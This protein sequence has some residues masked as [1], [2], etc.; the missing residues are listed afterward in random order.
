MCSASV[1]GIRVV[2]HGVAHHAR[3]SR[4]RLDPQR[5]TR[6]SC[7]KLVDDR[8][9]VIERAPTV[10]AERGDT[11]RGDRRDHIGRTQAHHRVCS[12]VE[13][14]RHDERQGAD[15]LH[16]LD[17][18]ERLLECEERLEHEQVDTAV[19]ECARLLGICLDADLARQQAVRLRQLAGRA[20][21]AGNE[22]AVAR[23]RSRKLRCADVQLAAAPGE[24]PVG[25]TRCRSAERAREHEVGARVEEATV[26]LPHA[27]G[28]VEDP[29]LGCDAWLD[30][31]VL[32]V[33]AGC[34]VCEQDGTGGEHV[35][36]RG[37]RASVCA[38]GPSRAT[39]RS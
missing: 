11:E 36:E 32:V 37:H 27:F 22:A 28:R 29:L 24:R 23:L 16:A 7:E 38:P 2:D 33:R 12:L 8:V 4:V 18:P 17:R 5:R 10:R 39:V 1:V 9:G 19:V 26:Q 25:E 30:A 3:H 21:R 15:V 6:R 31:H 20:E 13:A 14:E 35:G 34:T